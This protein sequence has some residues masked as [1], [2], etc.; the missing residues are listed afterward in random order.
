M[1]LIKESIEFISDK[2]ICRGILYLPNSHNKTPCVVMAH[3]FS[4]TIDWILPDF[5]IK[6]TE[7]GFAVLTFDYRN[8]GISDGSP[9]Q[10]IKR[11]LQLEDLKNAVKFARQHR[12][13]DPSR[14]ILWGTSLGGSHVTIIAAEDKQ[15]FGVIA[16]A[17]AIDVFKGKN[18]S[19]NIRIQKLNKLYVLSITLVLI[20]KALYD[21]IRGILGFSPYYI[22]VYGKPGK[23]IFTDPSLK[24]NFE[25]LE[26][27]SKKWKNKITPRFLFDVPRYSEAVFKNINCPVLF[28]L[29]KYDLEVSSEFIKEKSLNIK[30]V[31]IIEYPVAHFDLYHGEPL[32]KVLEDQTNFLIK[33]SKHEKNESGSAF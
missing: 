1:M 27:K 26:G 13:I 29:A 16:N 3:G 17:P 32:K 30:Q 23:A 7:N 12:S 5:A 8:F 21:Q 10:L 33:L 18:V 19:N 14:I 2:T 9:R 31:T 6:F 22:K 4:G 11:K 24:N 28:T 25:N 20:L 15:I